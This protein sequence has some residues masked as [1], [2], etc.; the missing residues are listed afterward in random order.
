MDVVWTDLHRHQ[1]PKMEINLGQPIPTYERPDRAETI[2]Q[3]LETDSRFNFIGLKEHGRAP[4]EAVHALGLI[5]YLEKAWPEIHAATGRS[6]FAPEAML[7]IGLREGMS[8]ARPPHGA[9]AAFG[10]WCYETATPMVEG[11]LLRVHQLMWLSPQQKRFLLVLLRRMA[12][13][14]RQDTTPRPM[15]LVAFAISIMRPS[16]RIMLRQQLVPK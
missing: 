15:C 4:I 16:L 13:V 3:Q 14:G 12:C 7:H 5:D 9:A 8:A 1:N 10:Y 11:T 6:E 2:R